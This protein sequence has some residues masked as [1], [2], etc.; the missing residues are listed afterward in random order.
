M[1][2]RDLTA[3]LV[4][5]TPKIVRNCE[6]W[7]NGGVLL[8]PDEPGVDGELDRLGAFGGREGRMIV[9]GLIQ[10]RCGPVARAWEP[11][12]NWEVGRPTSK[13]S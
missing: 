5:K 7:A 12:I 10:G 13:I 1:E 3:K 2:T 8:P 9:R 11:W 4:A 6:G